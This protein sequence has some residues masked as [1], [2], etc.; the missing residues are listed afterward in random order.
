[1]LKKLTCAQTDSLLPLYVGD[2]LAPA[3]RVRADKH[4]AA[5][6][7]CQQELALY[8]ESGALL[9][10]MSD[11]TPAFDQEFFATIRARTLASINA[12]TA[13][14][15]V[16]PNSRTPFMSFAPVARFTRDALRAS[17]S[18]AQ[19]STV[20]FSSLRGRAVL[21]VSAASMCALIVL[22][23]LALR[24]HE[25]TVDS[26]AHNDRIAVFAPRAANDNRLVLTDD[27]AKQDA[28][29]L[30]T[31]DSSNAFPTRTP[32]MTDRKRT[33]SQ[34]T[35]RAD[36]NRTLVSR[37]E[38]SIGAQAF[39]SN[40]DISR[41]VA[42][43]EARDDASSVARQAVATTFTAPVVSRIMLQTADP[44]VRI[45]WFTSSNSPSSPSSQPALQP[46]NA[47]PDEPSPADK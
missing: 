2:D 14:T 41:A 37:R 36:I 39:G 33:G 34:T 30:E 12:E 25:A 4:L 3:D 16:A 10:E 43:I 38:K 8:V 15:A 32:S 18:R 26:T 24:A 35:S 1:M 29:T 7:R 40:R 27:T 44:N 28:R 20:R 13:R 23:W 21:A 11:A 22:G 45:I 42:M 47:L 9:Q 31:Q 46:T 5:C 17:H 6:A 19:T